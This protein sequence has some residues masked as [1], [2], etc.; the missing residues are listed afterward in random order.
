MNHD[1]TRNLA[2]TLHQENFW[3]A[4]IAFTHRTAYTLEASSLYMCAICCYFLPA[5]NTQSAGAIVQPATFVELRCCEF[6]PESR[7][8]FKE[9]NWEIGFITLEVILV[10][11]ACASVNMIMPYTDWKTKTRWIKCI[12]NHWIKNRIF[13]MGRVGKP[14]SQ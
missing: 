11:Y 12:S 13:C 6:G 10:S 4:D 1:S 9:K 3:C 2:S 8:F 14:E 5:K 7:A